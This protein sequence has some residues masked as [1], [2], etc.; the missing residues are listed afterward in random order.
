MV[1]KKKTKRKIV[2]IDDVGDARIEE[3]EQENITKYQDLL[4][5]V[6]HLWNKAIHCYTNSDWGLWSNTQRTSLVSGNSEFNLNKLI[7]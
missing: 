5:E 1:I 3:K 2:F 4:F 7:L 6:E